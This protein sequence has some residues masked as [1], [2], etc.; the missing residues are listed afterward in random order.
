MGGN[1]TLIGTGGNGTLA[2]GGDGIFVEGV[3]ITSTSGNISL[4]GIG[5]IG[6]FWSV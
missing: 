4:T 3:S 5:G 2:S 6:D 1:I